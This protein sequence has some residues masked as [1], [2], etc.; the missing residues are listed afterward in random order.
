[1]RTFLLGTLFLVST[2][3]ASDAKACSCIPPRPPAQ[4]LAQASTVFSGRVLE[5]TPVTL[6]GSRR[7]TR[8]RFTVLNTWKGDCRKEV[9]IFTTDHTAM[10]GYPFRHH[11]SYLVYTYADQSGR[12]WASLC[13]RTKELGQAGEDLKVL[14]EGSCHEPGSCRCPAGHAFEVSSGRCVPERPAACP[15]IYKPVCGCDHKTYSNSCVA[16]SYGIKRWTEG[17]CH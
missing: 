10:C 11:E 3:A 7:V 17:A 1:M 12:L 15:H 16:A 9:E 4:A 2:I 6:E 14:G 5:M 13:S 8:V